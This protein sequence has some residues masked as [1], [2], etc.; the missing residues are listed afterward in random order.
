MKWKLDADNDAYTL[1]KG[2]VRCRVW[3]MLGA[4]Q[5]IVSVRGEAISGYNFATAEAACAW[6]EQHV[7]KQKAGT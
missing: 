6:C 2:E 3:R 7:A 1:A 5:A 4:W